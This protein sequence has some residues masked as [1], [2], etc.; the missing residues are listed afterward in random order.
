MNNF[1]N[2]FIESAKQ[3]YDV[4]KQCYLNISTNYF[5]KYFKNSL[6]RL[7]E[8]DLDD[9]TNCPEAYTLIN[10]FKCYALNDFDFEFYA[11]FN[12]LIP[13]YAIRGATRNCL[14]FLINK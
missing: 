11:L 6:S 5:R 10:G 3:R 7:A 14:D 2:I 12:E 8:N 13:T 4:L 9:L 1:S